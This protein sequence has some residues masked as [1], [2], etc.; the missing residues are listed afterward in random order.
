MPKKSSPFACPAH[1]SPFPVPN[2][3]FPI[4]CTSQPPELIFKSS[5]VPKPRNPKARSAHHTLASRSQ[6]DTQPELRR[7]VQNP[8]VPPIPH[9]RASRLPPV[10]PF[11]R[12]LFPTPTLPATLPPY[13]FLQRPH[14]HP[15]AS[16]RQ[17][18]PS[19]P[20]F[21]LNYLTQPI[22]L[23]PQKSPI[24]MHKKAKKKKKKRKAG[25]L[26]PRK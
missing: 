9:P 3:L 18:Q 23:H 21:T 17:S 8:S 24:R 20:K 14:M 22:V 5:P 4:P 6:R 16:A 1:A 7:Y 13:P 11:C 15:H 2:T 12:L 25:P 19:P 10:V 26:R